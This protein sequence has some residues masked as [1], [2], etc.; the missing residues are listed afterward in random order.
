VIVQP[1]AKKGEPK[2]SKKET[3]KL[4][5]NKETLRDMDVERIDAD[6][7]KGGGQCGRSR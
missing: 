6:K 7:V 4:E 1:N 2:D 3:E 5:L